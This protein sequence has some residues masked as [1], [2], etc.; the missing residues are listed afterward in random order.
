MGCFG[1]GV[2]AGTHLGWDTW[3]V[4]SEVPRAGG[5]LGCGEWGVGNGPGGGGGGQ[6][7]QGAAGGSQGLCVGGGQDAPQCLL[8][9]TG[10]G[11][12]AR[13]ESAR[14][15]RECKGGGHPMGV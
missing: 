1:Q 3:E 7:T 2:L 8:G 11:G 15:C 10:W 9:C 12:G 4:L 6:F 14:G 13:C 5:T